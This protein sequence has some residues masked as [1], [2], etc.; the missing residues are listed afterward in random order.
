[1]GIA[2]KEATPV[3]GQLSILF[4]QW[5]EPSQALETEVRTLIQEHLRELSSGEQCSLG[6]FIETISL[7]QSMLRAASVSNLFPAARGAPAGR[8][9][10]TAAAGTAQPRTPQ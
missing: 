5:T 2:L 9:N 8:H 3:M 4:S 10:G 6:K 1:M 7:C